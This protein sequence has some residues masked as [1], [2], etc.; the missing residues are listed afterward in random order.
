VRI[1]P[2]ACDFQR[3][4][5]SDV[6]LLC[7]VHAFPPPRLR[8][9]SERHPPRPPSLQ[10]L[11]NKS[12]KMP[13]SPKL[14]TWLCGCFVALGSGMFPFSPF[15][16]LNFPNTH[17]S[18][19]VPNRPRSPPLRPFSHVRIRSR[20]L[21]SSL[22]VF[23][24]VPDTQL[25]RCFRRVSSPVFFPPRISSERPT[26]PTRTTSASS[27]LRSCS[28]PSSVASRLPTSLMRT[29]EGRLF[30]LEA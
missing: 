26:T 23:L 7:P 24:T 10:H 20:T 9:R 19:C 21:P 6:P 2:F 30:L 17:P 16:R 27:R 22:L 8:A 14:Y 11:P 25:C 4:A 28:V 13:M 18:R 29:V 3:S 12:I 5:G 15:F 1:V